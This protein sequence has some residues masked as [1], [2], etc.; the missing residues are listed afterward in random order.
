[1][2]VGLD[3]YDKFLL[4][5]YVGLDTYDKENGCLIVVLRHVNAM[6]SLLNPYLRHGGWAGDRRFSGPLSRWIA[7]IFWVGQTVDQRFSRLV[8]ARSGGD[9]KPL[10]ARKI[11]LLSEK[12]SSRVM[13]CGTSPDRLLI[14]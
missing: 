10:R 6:N 12:I 14:H 4:H 13:V 8:E 2:Y 11:F 1:M 9:Q 3:T 5:K 7:R